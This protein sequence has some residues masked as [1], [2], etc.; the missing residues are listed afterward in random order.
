[1]RAKDQL[2]DY[3]K[4]LTK[5]NWPKDEQQGL[6][7]EFEL[8]AYAMCLNHLLPVLE[9]ISKVEDFSEMKKEL[10]KLVAEQN[11]FKD[12]AFEHLLPFTPAEP[13]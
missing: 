10:T 8:Y 2:M 9:N 3:T 6:K 4:L 12:F 11:E 13:K 5:E 7:D 1:M